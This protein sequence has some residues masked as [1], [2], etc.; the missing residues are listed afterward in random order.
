MSAVSF[1]SVY[2]MESHFVVNNDVLK[3][4]NDVLS[5]CLDSN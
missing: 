3:V 4:R 1:D 5:T 2:F